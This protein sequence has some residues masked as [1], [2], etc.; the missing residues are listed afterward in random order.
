MVR[1][2]ECGTE[3]QKPFA[4][5]SQPP[6][7]KAAGLAVWHRVSFISEAMTFVLELCSAQCLCVVMIAPSV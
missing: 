6:R 4:L 2:G 3:G 1:R 5:K 7:R